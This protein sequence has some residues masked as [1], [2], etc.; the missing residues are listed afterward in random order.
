MFALNWM[1]FGWNWI[2]KLRIRV[3]IAGVA[4]PP[5]RPEETL[6][7]S[8]HVSEP[9]ARGAVSPPPAPQARTIVGIDAYSLPSQEKA[10]AAPLG[11]NRC[12]EIPLAPG[13]EFVA[14]V[15]V[16]SVPTGETFAGFNYRLNFDDN[17][18]KIV[19]QDYDLLLSSDD[20]L[21][22]NLGDAVPDT[23]S[24]HAA[25]TTNLNWNVQ[26]PM[27]GVLTRYTFQILPRALRGVTGI[28]L[29]D[30]ELFNGAGS[31]L[32]VDDV[33]NLRVALGVPCSHGGPP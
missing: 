32:H 29:T 22:L 6:I 24:P 19:G 15:F 10:N 18:F 16:D 30:V 20:P 28:S 9:G 11:P 1:R 3:A 33:W 12:S 4:S 23:K 25:A 17:V 8:E 7:A 21:L 31:G 13:S 2:T 26:G 5:E 27:K 14:D